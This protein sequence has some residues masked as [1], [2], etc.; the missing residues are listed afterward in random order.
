MA[1]MLGLL[2]E[3]IYEVSLASGATIYMPSVIKIQSK[4]RFFFSNL[5]GCNVGFTD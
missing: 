1:V 4:S 3:V 2:E 5:K